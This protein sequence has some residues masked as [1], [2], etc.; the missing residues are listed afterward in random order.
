[1]GMYAIKLLK[2]AINEYRK[3]YPGFFD[4]SF[5]DCRSIKLL[6]PF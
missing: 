1:M 5:K 3:V 6:L 4:K 2:R